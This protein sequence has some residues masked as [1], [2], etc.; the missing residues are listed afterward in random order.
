MLSQKTYNVLIAVV[1]VVAVG[2]GI[3][4]GNG[5][6]LLKGD[7]YGMDTN[8][9]AGVPW[10]CIKQPSTE[11]DTSSKPVSKTG[12]YNRE[13]LKVGKSPAQRPGTWAKDTN[14]PGSSVE[15][16]GGL[17]G[18]QATSGY[19]SKKEKDKLK[20]ELAKLDK[21]SIKST[22]PTIGTSNGKDTVAKGG[23]RTG[24][25]G[26]TA[27]TPKTTTSPGNW[28][29]DGYVNDD[30]EVSIPDCPKGY[31]KDQWIVIKNCAQLK[32]DLLNGKYTVAT[33]PKEL[34]EL[35]A[36]CEHTGKW[37]TL[38]ATEDDCVKYLKNI[39]VT[40][41]GYSSAMSNYC[42][43]V[44]PNAYKKAIVSFYDDCLAWSQ[45]KKT[46]DATQAAACKKQYP[47]MMKTA[48]EDECTKILETVNKLLSMGMSA[49]EI[50]DG[51]GGKIQYCANKYPGKITKPN[52]SGMFPIWPITGEVPKNP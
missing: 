45:G 47:W 9:P 36:V 46:L 26:T 7:Y 21:E 52:S 29:T 6:N 43:R 27:V 28:N 38:T 12:G 16:A 14:T 2:L 18:G 31:Y 24:N 15:I 5:G 40:G 33:L 17:T 37:F 10:W 41:G 32:M 8:N 3:S 35:Y 44:H 23:G 39:Q 42:G 25:I 11:P 34:K 20:G 48:T 49:A 19:V 50:L 51:T 4:F 30:G 13:T 22:R 1:T